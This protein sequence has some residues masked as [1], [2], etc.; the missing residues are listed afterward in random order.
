MVVSRSKAAV[1]K[2]S[3]DEYFFIWTHGYVDY[4]WKIL[5]MTF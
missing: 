5:Y 1:A 2:K 3:A 4:L